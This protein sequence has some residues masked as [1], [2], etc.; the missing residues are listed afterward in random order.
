MR[1]SDM[2]PFEKEKSISEIAAPT[3]GAV[4]ACV[5]AWSRDTNNTNK[6]FCPKCNASSMYI[7]KTL[8]LKKNKCTKCKL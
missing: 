1:I 6:L 8:F 3:S 4:I 7:D 5:T 2:C